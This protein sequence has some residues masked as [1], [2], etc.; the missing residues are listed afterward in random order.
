MN[1]IKENKF[2]FLFI[3]L[4]IIAIIVFILNKITY[5]S[6]EKNYFYFDTYINIKIYANKDKKEV[7]KIFNEIDYL[8]SSYHK[9][10]DKY[11]SYDNIINI[12]YLNEILENNKEIEIDPRLSKLISIGIDYYNKTNGY[13]NIASS[14][15]IDIWK[16]YIDSKDKVPELSSLENANINISDITLENNTYTK[17]N[18][19]KLDLGSY[20]KGYITDLIANYLESLKID[21]Y[22]IDAGGNI[23]VGNAYKKDNYTIGIQDP[24][25]TNTIF[26]KLNI[27]NLSVVTSGDYQR[28]YEYNGIRYNHIIN[29]YTKMPSNNFKSVTVITNSSL[30]ADI[31]STYLFLIDLDTGLD[32][33]KNNS[34]LKVIWY[35]DKDNIIKSEDYN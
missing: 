29:P 21:K 8:C 18:N 4:F 19:I 13:I 26:T 12:Y 22:L 2:L 27:N 34:D 35:I 30:V 25:N 32:I 28:Y 11:N 10:T 14:N 17:N 15:L 31:Y 24:I 5:T 23:K 9:L 7:D 33:V 3:L 1:K 16:S 20:T 6:Y